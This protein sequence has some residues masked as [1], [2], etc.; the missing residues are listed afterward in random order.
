MNDMPRAFQARFATHNLN[1]WL[2]ALLSLLG[3]AAV[4]I[5][6]GTFLAALAFLIDTV[7]RGESGLVTFQF[8][9]IA[10]Q[11]AG[12]IRNL[13]VAVAPR[14]LVPAGAAIGA[15]LFLWA[16]VDR[17]HRRFRPV[18]DRPIIG[19][20]LFGEILL[21][22]ARMVLGIWDHLTARVRLSTAEREEAWRLLQIIH[23]RG[24]SPR[25]ELAADVSDPRMLDRLL[26]ALQVTGWIDLH[27]GDDDWFYLIRGDNEHELRELLTE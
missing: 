20:H 10:E 4:W 21:L 27:R 24:R 5:L 25:T 14:W 23:E 11:S 16:V 2:A 22:P 17:W 6:V 19:W 13:S 3:A 12:A 26:D 18:T 1:C 8:D 15:G 9:E 7:I